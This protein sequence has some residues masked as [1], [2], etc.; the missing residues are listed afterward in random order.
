MRDQDP[1]FSGLVKMWHLPGESTRSHRDC[2]GCWF[3]EKLVG[4]F[5]ADPGSSHPCNGQ[6]IVDENLSD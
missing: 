2:A 1:N 5:E 6:K 3:G 4:L